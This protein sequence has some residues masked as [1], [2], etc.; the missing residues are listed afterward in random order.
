VQLIGREDGYGGD[1]QMADRGQTTLAHG[2]GWNSPAAVT[3]ASNSPTAPTYDTNRRRWR[4]PWTIT[5][6]LSH[7][8]RRIRPH[9]RSS[10]AMRQAFPGGVQSPPCSHPLS[11]SMAVMSTRVYRDARETGRHPGEGSYPPVK[12][13]LT[14]P[15]HA[16]AKRRGRRTR[17]TS[18]S[19][20]DK[21][22]PRLGGS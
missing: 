17:T 6:P 16:R 21:W 5:T 2:E 10:P 12:A 20:A 22:G 18:G 3:A 8:P 7:T 14:P 1:L 11:H 13:T 4:Q 19:L 9:R 15:I